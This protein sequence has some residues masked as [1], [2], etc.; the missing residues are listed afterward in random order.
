[1]SKPKLYL[2]AIGGTGSRVLTSLTM[3]LA[4]GIKVNAEVIVPMIIDT[5]INNGDVEKCRNV[6]KNY[7]AIHTSLYQNVGE[8]ED[9]GHFFRTKILPPKELNISGTSYGT[10]REMVNYNTLAA[11]GFGKTKGLFDLLYNESNKNMQLEK[12]FLGNPNVGSVVLKNVVETKQFKEFTQDFKQEDRIFIISSIFGGTGAAGFPLL[13]NVFRDDNSKLNNSN[14]INNAVI[15]GVSV[16]PYFQVDVDKFNRGESAINSSTFIT[17]SKAALSYYNRNLKGL[18]NALYYVGDT[19]QSSYE[20]FDGGLEQKNPANFVELTAAKSVVEFLDFEPKAK[21][22]DD[23]SQVSTFFEFGIEEDSS[24]LN[25]KHLNQNGQIRQFIKF[26]YY[27]LYISNYLDEAFKNDKL[28]WRNELKLP[29][30]YE[31]QPFIQNLKNFTMRYYY[32]WLLEL[33]LERHNRKYIPFDLSIIQNQEELV[34]DIACSTP[35][36]I[37]MDEKKMFTLVNSIP[38]ND[39]SSWIKKDKF[40]YDEVFSKDIKSILERQLNSK[41]RELNV[42]F[43]QGLEDII[44]RRFSNI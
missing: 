9:L 31:K 12:G 2:F 26:H 16:L 21:S 8:D 17:K 22:K 29:T 27:N 5:D 36:Q 43:N 19:R 23:L 6:I 41:E 3:L 33:G 14:Y 28:A 4:S 42:M 44:Q 1:M 18:V 13:L 30:N 25:L 40:R 39:S 10:L 34:K 11:S 7:N 32:K 15:G 20:N 24:N 38:A 35:A 37:N